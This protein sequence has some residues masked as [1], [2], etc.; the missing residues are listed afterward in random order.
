MAAVSSTLDQRVTMLVSVPSSCSY[1]I[2]QGAGGPMK[3]DHDQ[4]LHS[5]TEMRPL[6]NRFPER[7]N[8]IEKWLRAHRPLHGGRKLRKQVMQLQ[9]VVFHCDLKSIL[10]GGIGRTPSGHQDVV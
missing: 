3:R 4:F 10:V 6:I 1:G 9:S 5:H 8:V 2:I 7:I